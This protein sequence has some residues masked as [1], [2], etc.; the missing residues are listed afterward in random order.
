LPKVRRVTAA[1]P[2]ANECSSAWPGKRRT[3][4][5]AM[6]KPKSIVSSVHAN[7]IVN[8]G[9]ARARDVLELIDR[10]RERVRA[11]SGVSL[12]LEIQLV[13]FGQAA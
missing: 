12:E 8:E 4:Q 6:S 9:G 11:D 1:P 2:S 13:G 5:R 3:S 10:I 7:Y